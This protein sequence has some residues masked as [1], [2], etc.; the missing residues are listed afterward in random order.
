MS[1]RDESKD[2]L[3]SGALRKA[4][5][6]TF[7]KDRDTVTLRLIRTIVEQQHKLGQ[8]YFKT[9]PYWKE[10]SKEII[11]EEVVS[12]P[13]LEDGGGNKGGMQKA[14]KGSVELQLS[15]LKLVVTFPA[16]SRV[17]SCSCSFP[18]SSPSAP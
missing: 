13:K 5:A 6:Q 3:L 15:S 8:D 9:D 10:R 14:A 4:V 16:A 1:D 17:P 7:A 18:S 2:I 11:M 12:Y